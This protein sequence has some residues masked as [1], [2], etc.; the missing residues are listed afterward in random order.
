VAGV[1]ARGFIVGAPLAYLLGCGFVPLR[2]KGKLPGR[3]IGHDYA[4]EYGT[5]RIEMHVDAVSPDERVLVVDD[6][7]AT[8]GTAEAASAIVQGAGA[9]VVECAFVVELPDLGGRRRLESAGRK[10]FALCEF[11]GD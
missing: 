6:L 10:V 9:H 11:A 8:G 1:E 3:A 7:L 2:K 4:L 5:D